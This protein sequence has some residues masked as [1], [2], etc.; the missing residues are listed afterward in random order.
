[1]NPASVWNERKSTMEQERRFKRLTSLHS[2]SDSWIQTLSPKEA[3][4]Y[5]LERMAKV[6]LNP[7]LWQFEKNRLDQLPLNLEELVGAQDIDSFL[8]ELESTIWII[9]ASTL[10]N[11][12]TD[13]TNRGELKNILEQASWNHG[14]LHAESIW[15]NPGNFNLREGVEAF[16]KTHVYSGA[17]FLIERNSPREITLLWKQSPRQN[18]SLRNSPALDLLCDLHEHWIRGF[19]Y[20]ASRNTAV[21]IA[22]TR[23]G[24]EVFPRFTLR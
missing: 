24:E 13:A 17:G 20:G 19:F 14:K 3:A 1:M 12:E 7:N 4:S 5:R 22:P 23:L 2:L 8:A 15:G 9:Q 18:P 10:E 21:S 11:A 6:T 16:M